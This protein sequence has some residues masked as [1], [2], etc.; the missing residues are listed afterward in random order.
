MSIQSMIH[1]A[2]LY[3]HTYIASAGNVPPGAN[4]FSE[5]AHFPGTVSSLYL[6][7]FTAGE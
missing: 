3:V 1:A 6:L 2:G 7:R 4:A 5:H